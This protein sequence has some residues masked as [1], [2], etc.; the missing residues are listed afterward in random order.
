M[1]SANS[2]LRQ[3]HDDYIGDIKSAA[4]SQSRRQDQITDEELS[5]IEG[6]MLPQVLEILKG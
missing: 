3:A 1:E 5:V 6:F 4:Q 2:D